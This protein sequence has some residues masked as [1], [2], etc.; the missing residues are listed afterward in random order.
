MIAEVLVEIN[1]NNKEQTFSYLIPDN[2]SVEIGCRVLVPFG[3]RKL[4]G[5]VLNVHDHD[6]IKNNNDIKLKYIETIL[7]EFPVLTDELIELGKYMSRKTLSSLINCYQAMLPKALK[8]KQ[9]VNINKKLVKYL[10]L[11]VS[12]EEALNK[13][14]NDK[15][16][17]II[18]ALKN[19]KLPIS[20]INIINTSYKT[21]LKNGVLKE[22]LIEDYRI[23]N[24]INIISKNIVLNEEQMH[25]VES[26]KLSTFT[27][28]L[29]YGVTGSGKTEVYMHI[30]ENVIEKGNE[31]IILV[32]EIS[33]TPQLINNF[34]ERFGDNIAVL[35]SGLS[36]G[37]KYDEWR[38]IKRQ[39]VKIV[40]GAR[41]AIFAPFTNL[42]LIVMD[43]E[44]VST[45]KQENNPK[46]STHDMAIFRAKYNN[47][48]VI[49]GSATPSIESYTRAINNV[50]KLIELKKRVNNSLPNVE[51]IDMK[52]E[53]KHG[54]KIIS[55]SLK[56]K[57]ESIIEKKEQAIILLNRRGFS[58]ITTC[59]NCGYVHKCK[60][61]D[62]PLTYHKSSNSYKCHYCGYTTS[63]LSVCPVCKSDD[64][65]NMGL[66]TE[67]LE[68][69]INKNIKGAKVIRM[70][71]DT[72]SRKGSHERI[73]NSFKNG[74]ANILLGTQ[75]IAKGLDFPNVTLVGV[76]NADATLNVPD[77]R[78]SE[79]TFQLLNQV[80]GRS[81]RAS[82]K[83][84]VVIQA[85]NT[86][87][88]SIVLASKNRY[89]D[90]YEKEISYRKKLLYPPYCN[91]ALIKIS[92]RYEN[93]VINESNKIVKYL[94]SV[95]A[96]D[97]IILGPSAPS[98]YKINNTFNMQIILKY[99]KTENIY[100]HL[101][102]IKNLYDNKKIKVEIDIN[103][104]KI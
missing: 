57:L 23:K 67:K 92:S 51:I 94:N 19:N 88:Y 10:S 48:P 77:F 100:N 64:L 61:C 42:G 14:K 6:K 66:G 18:N 44:H 36:D 90:F 63:N 84:N 27:P 95:K 83:G 71:V 65:D 15:Q 28:Y 45:Y 17:E 41:S 29:L 102:Y 33:L 93:E 30:I 87:H 86:D 26:V 101:L 70:D 21:L 91:L 39:E 82:L 79:R 4:E 80:S 9:G 54:N 69:Y 53:Y 11:K 20:S 58:T 89:L 47:I 59:K 68:E 56:E 52:D 22:E 99:K 46:Y 78:S 2:L 7:D 75:M 8:A 43:E 98:M 16:E 62:I 50:Y 32:P 5:F 104:I 12:Y 60:N 72:T 74:D 3:N 76:I 37:E 31:V 97:V 81:G 103:P 38:K 24:N 49:F 85:F 35:H 13:A 96:K 73:I 25:A 40:I 34:R 1:F 55:S